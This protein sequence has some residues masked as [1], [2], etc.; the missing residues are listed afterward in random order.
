MTAARL[1]TSV[2][3]EHGAWRSGLGDPAA[4]C[5]KASMAGWTLGRRGLPENHTLA[6]PLVAPVEISVLLTGDAEIRALNRDHRGKDRPTNVLSFPGDDSPGAPGQ[7]ILL[8]DIVLA[9]ETVAAEARNESKPVDDHT[10]H[11]V[12]HGVLH[13]LGY[14]HESRDDASLMEG[15]EVDSLARL[16]V[17]DPYKGG[18]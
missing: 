4:L 14:D 9:W 17:P 6:G 18:G 16:G 8:G 13:L 3:I 1:R 15:L 7:D 10:R 11:L 12:I 2:R 5:R